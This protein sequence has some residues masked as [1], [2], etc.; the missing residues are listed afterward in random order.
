MYP[1]T[2]ISEVNVESLVNSIINGDKLPPIKVCENTMR[3][4][5]GFHRVEAHKRLKLEHIEAELKSY[6]NDAEFYRDAVFPNAIHGRQFTPFD[7][8]R[9]IKRAEE[10]GMTREQIG[11]MLRIKPDRLDK[12]TRDV[13][14]FMS[15][16]VPIK[17]SLAPVLANTELTPKQVELNKKWGGM[18]ISF[19]IQQIIDYL[20]AVDVY[21]VKVAEKLDRL[22]ELWMSKSE[23]KVV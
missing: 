15:Q 23:S 14:T 3:V 11:E 5:D 6:K 10:L 7:R 20:E 22:T 17:R 16:Q 8:K 9:I 21:D 18:N 4:V 12:L 1:R 2:G 19:Y 13:A